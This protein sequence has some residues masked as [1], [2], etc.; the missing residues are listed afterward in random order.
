MKKKITQNKIIVTENIR[1]LPDF[2][3]VDFA[4]KDF[5]EANILLKQTGKYDEGLR[6]IEAIV[7]PLKSLESTRKFLFSFMENTDKLFRKRAY[8]LSMA[9]YMKANNLQPAQMAGNVLSKARTYAMKEAQKATYTDASKAA[10]AL[11][12]LKR[13]A[14]TSE[15]NLYKAPVVEAKVFPGQKYETAPSLPHC[16]RQCR[17]LL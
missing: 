15:N 6:K 14:R 17:S 2:K 10:D 9:Q 8:E 4:R 5:D 1:N 16:S 13:K 12:R 3:L 11:A 7:F